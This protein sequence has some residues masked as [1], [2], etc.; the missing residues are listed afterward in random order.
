MRYAKTSMGRKKKN[1]ER[2]AGIYTR[3]G[4]ILFLPAEGL[5]F[6]A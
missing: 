2:S 6:A 4:G 5:I 3:R 1:A